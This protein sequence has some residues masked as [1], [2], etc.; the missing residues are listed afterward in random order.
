[1]LTIIV[2]WRGSAEDLPMYFIALATDFDGTIAEDGVVAEATLEAL[3]ELK[4]SER[5]LLLVT[6]RQLPDLKAAF[7]ELGLFNMVVATRLLERIPIRQNHI[8]RCGSNLD[9]RLAGS[10]RGRC[11]CLPRG[12]RRFGEPFFATCF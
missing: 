1:M 6:G 12:R 9:T 5:K 4:R 2:P 7:P 3:R 8:Q 10:H 11:R